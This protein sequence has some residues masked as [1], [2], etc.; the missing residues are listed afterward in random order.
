MSKN[1]KKNYQK[2]NNFK[3]KNNFN[4]NHNFKN[5][6]CVRITN[7]PSDITIHELA[8]LVK[9]WSDI[10]RINFN[11]SNRFKNA[12]I[13]FY[14]KEEADYFVKALDKTPFDNLIIGVEIIDN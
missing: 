9:E 11:N 7:L 2:T 14:N 10:G 8:S 12:Y 4:K 5:K 13:D 3:N 6:I 1:Y